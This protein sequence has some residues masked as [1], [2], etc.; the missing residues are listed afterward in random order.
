MKWIALIGPELEENLGIRYISSSLRTAGF[1]TAIIP[2]NAGT[3]LSRTLNSITTAEV[4]PLMIAISLSFQSRAMDCLALIL[5]LR[6]NGYKGHITSGGHF[7]YF[8][9]KELLTDFKEIDSI[10]CGE[11]EEVMVDLA[12]AL[13]SNQPHFYITGLCCRNP[14]GSIIDNPPRSAPD[15]ETLPWPDRVGKRASCLDHQIAA[16]V[17]GRGCYGNCTFCCIT[18]WHRS[19]TAN[20]PY[21]LR[22]LEDIAD[23]MAWLYFKHNIEIFI[24]HDDNFFLPDKKENLKRISTL[25]SILKRHGIGRFATMVKARPTDITPEILSVMKES[26]GLYRLFL[27]V[28]NDSSQGL[29][30]LGRGVSQNQNHRAMD[31]LVDSN[32]Y[33]CFNLLMFEPDAT[34]ESLTTNLNFIKRFGCNPFFFGR[35]ELYAGT[36]L[37]RRMQNEKLANGNYISW[38][39]QLRDPAVQRAFEY[40]MHSFYD[41][42]FSP[43]SSVLCL[44]TV[45]HD[46]EICRI[47]HPE[48]YKQEW[49]KRV[50][51]LCQTLADDTVTHMSTIVD[52]AVKDYHT[53]EVLQEISQI[54]KKI[55]LMDKLI[56]SETEKL[57]TEVHTLTNRNC[58]HERPLLLTTI[59]PPFG[60]GYLSG[61]KQQPL[62]VLFTCKRN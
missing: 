7:G 23:E 54:S 17:G 32:I 6:E 21:R 25:S 1:S 48:I 16:I 52:V 30:T 18:A 55:Q 56:R 47:F 44:M 24:F 15:I 40:Y 59:N 36:P 49:L 41:R 51:L 57:T 46:I 5:A 28:E 43:D 3:D 2:F 9:R 22:P 19:N 50:N 33:T 8:C 14:D 10:C 20:K 27:G 38:N 62:E 61:K 37:L 34:I 42:N 35:V 31:L 39:Y 58:S 11:S 29:A 12:Q 45:K 13:S 53:N 60:K 4:P 26:F